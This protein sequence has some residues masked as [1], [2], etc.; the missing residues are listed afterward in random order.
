MPFKFIPVSDTH[1]DIERI[2]EIPVQKDTTVLLAG[3]I[4]EVKKK[5]QYKEILSVFSE[6]F[7]NVILICGNHEYYTRSIFQVHDDLEI[8]VKDFNN[9]IFLDNKTTVID[10]VHIIGST[11]WTDFGKDV[12]CKLQAQMQMNDYKYIRNGPRGIPYKRKLN[13]QDVEFMNYMSN[14]FIMDEVQRIQ[15]LESEPKFII[16]THHAP[17]MR[18]VPECFKGSKLNAAFA[19]DMDSYMMTLPKCV[20]V[21]GHIHNSVDYMVGNCHVISNPLGYGLERNDFNDSKYFEIL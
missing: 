2:K 14:I 6:K 5:N 1:G 13:I 9:V 12:L 18:S 8:M 4:H 3:D 19:N 11:L 7:K 17:S 16:L 10:G 20:W 15:S 21:H